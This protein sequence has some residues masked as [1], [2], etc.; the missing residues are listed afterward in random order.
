[1]EKTGEEEQR[2]KRAAE[3]KLAQISSIRD[4]P[5]NSISKLAENVSV[6]YQPDVW[7]ND[8]LFKVKLEL[9]SLQ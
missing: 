6:A 5:A 7:T 8:M 2:D 1:M 3:P 9:V 4:I